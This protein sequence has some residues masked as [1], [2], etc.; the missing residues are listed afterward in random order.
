MLK[1]G[2]VSASKGAFISDV[3]IRGIEATHRAKLVAGCFSRHPE[4]KC[5]GS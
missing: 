3:H 1:F 5:R 2:I 4:K